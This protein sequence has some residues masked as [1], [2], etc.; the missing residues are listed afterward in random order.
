ML[1]ADLLRTA[2]WLDRLGQ[3]VA[4]ANAVDSLE[5]AKEIEQEIGDLE[6]AISAEGELAALLAPRR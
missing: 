3:G 2:S 6:L 5:A 1:R 4:R